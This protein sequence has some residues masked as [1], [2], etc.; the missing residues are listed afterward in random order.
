[1]VILIYFTTYACTAY[2]RIYFSISSARCSLVL[3]VSFIMFFISYKNS[4]RLVYSY[5]EVADFVYEFIPV[6]S[7]HLYTTYVLLFYA[8]NFFRVKKEVYTWV[9]SRVWSDN[10]LRMSRSHCTRY[11]YL[12]D[13]IKSIQDLSLP[14]WKV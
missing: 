5:Q 7:I 12:L 9:V 6:P 11:V 14:L 2:S 10:P 3:V 1:V 4:G 13:S 8:T